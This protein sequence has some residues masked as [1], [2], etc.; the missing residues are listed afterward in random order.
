MQFKWKRSSA[1]ERVASIRTATH[2]QRKRGPGRIA[3]TLTS[4]LLK[5]GAEPIVHCDMVAGHPLRLDG[6]VPSHCWT[7]LAAI[8]AMA[9]IFVLE[10]LNT[11]KRTVGVNSNSS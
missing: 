1:I 4:L 3:S 8:A 7:F 5:S 11:F 2:M 6:R 10:V 9:A